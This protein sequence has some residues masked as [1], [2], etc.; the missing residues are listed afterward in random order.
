MIDFNEIF[1]NSF[2]RV[3]KNSRDFYIDFYR[4]FVASSPV[5]RDMFSNVDME[6][7]QSMLQDSMLHL[8]SFLATKQ[9]DAYL[10]DLAAS[11]LK[12]HKVTREMYDWWL[13]AMLTT[14]QRHDTKFN[15]HV[16]VAW[17]IAL[18]PGIA[19]MKYYRD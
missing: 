6:E 5:I 8:V 3:H 19:F 18:A 17:R 11:H 15:H 1:N 10:E 16:E 13:D 14:V 2:E 9:S 12:A 4:E 7:Q